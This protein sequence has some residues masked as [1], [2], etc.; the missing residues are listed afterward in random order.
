MT[1]EYMER[2]ANA[3]KATEYKYF[4][5]YELSEDQWD[6]VETLVSHAKQCA[7]I[8]PVVWE[9]YERN[10]GAWYKRFVSEK[11][12]GDRYRDIR[13]LY[14]IPAPEPKP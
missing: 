3:I 13:P 2:L 7:G 1:Q 6:A 5:D 12:E 4:G 9:C 10:M 11:P 8:E 14:F